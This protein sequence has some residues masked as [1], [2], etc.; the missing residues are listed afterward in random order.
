MQEVK[1][2]DLFIRLFHWSMV[3]IILLNF[4][5]FE[6]GTVH[7]WLGYSLLGLL[8]LRF[9]WGFVGP[10][11]ARFKNFIP[12]PRSVLSHIKEQ[13]E[14]QRT[15]YLGHNPLGAVMIINL[16]LTLIL[17]C[18]TGYLAITDRFWGVEWVEEAHEFFANYLLLSV[19][20]HI[21]GVVWESFRSHV[22]LILAM[23]TGIKKVP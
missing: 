21:M 12:S 6:E 9:I 8:G 14:G 22:N 15:V 5:V 3:M 16:Y 7:N 20:V 23:V 18:A 13:K 19:A 1:V 2:W 4:I 10:K 17:L 11:Y